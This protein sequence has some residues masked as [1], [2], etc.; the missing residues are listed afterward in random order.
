MLLLPFDTE[1]TGLPVYKAPSEREDQPHL[2][3]L[4]AILCDDKGQI[5]RQFE[6]IIKP[7]GWVIPDDIAEKNGI[8]TEVAMDVGIPEVEALE[9]FLELYNQCELR[10]AHSTN[11]DNRIIRIALQRHMFDLIPKEVWKDKSKY[12]CTLMKARKIMGG[13]SGHTL[14]EAYLHFTGKE[15]QNAHT[16]LADAS[17]CMEIYFAIKFLENE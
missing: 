8:T 11:F 1:T 7:D 2:T 17:A 3:Q 10:I 13:K 4:G 9:M 12:Y 14:T 16:A 5:A 6:V 15:L